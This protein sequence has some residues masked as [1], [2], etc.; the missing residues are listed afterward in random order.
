[1]ISPRHDEASFSPTTAAYQALLDRGASAGQRHSGLALTFARKLWP[2]A[3]IRA[4]MPR[5]GLFLLIAGRKA[6]FT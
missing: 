4:C 2:R 3:P 5:L 6:K 1:M